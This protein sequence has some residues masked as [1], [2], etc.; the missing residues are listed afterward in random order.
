MNIES[1]IVVLEHIIHLS[2]GICYQTHQK[3]PCRHYLWGQSVVSWYTVPTIS[4]M[5]VV[6]T[7]KS[8]SVESV[9]LAMFGDLGILFFLPVFVDD[10]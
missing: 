1:F 2:F 9:E 10:R 8:S 4:C 5:G 6:T 3:L 7:A